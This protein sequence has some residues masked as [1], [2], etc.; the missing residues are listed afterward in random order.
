MGR[1]Q[2]GMVGGWVGAPCDAPPGVQRSSW[3]ADG[4]LTVLCSIPE[5]RRRFMTTSRALSCSEE[6][7]A[8]RR[9]PRSGRQ[10]IS[11]PEEVGA[12]GVGQR[13]SG[14]PEGWR[15]ASGAGDISLLSGTQMAPEGHGHPGGHGERCSQP[16]SPRV[17]LSMLGFT[18]GGAARAPSTVALLVAAQR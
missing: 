11:T 15:A 18:G 9:P 12:E 3:V 16:P 10:H 14:C 17:A 4:S 1:T 13:G 8:F 2:G 7:E 6:T 5:V